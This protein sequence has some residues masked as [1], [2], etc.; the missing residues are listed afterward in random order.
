VGQVWGTLA[1]G[2]GGLFLALAELETLRSAGK[3]GWRRWL[4]WL[5]RV[6]TGARER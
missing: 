6:S 4:G 3:S 2:A 1:V 5:V